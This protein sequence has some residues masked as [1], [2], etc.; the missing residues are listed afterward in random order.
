MADS[1]ELARAREVG[2][3]VH[4]DWKTPPTNPAV[5][6]AA[7]RELYL[8]GGREERIWALECAEWA[9]YMIR[10]NEPDVSAAVTPQSVPNR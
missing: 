1:P 2:L 6:F 5:L 7:A 10:I 3:A 8:A 4:T 9:C